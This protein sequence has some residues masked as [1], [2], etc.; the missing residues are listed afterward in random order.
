MSR[1]GFAKSLITVTVLTGFF[2]VGCVQRK[3]TINTTPSDAIVIL[4][5]EEIGRSP[6][7]VGFEW[8]GDFSVQVEKP[9]YQTLA[10]HREIKRPVR[11]RFPFDLFTDL[12]GS[13]R[14]N[15]YEWSF[16]LEPYQEPNKDELIKAAEKLRAETI[17]E[18]E[19]PVLE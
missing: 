9:G 11:D 17:T 13:N 14:I 8:Y 2:L 15:S 3:L 6:V 1:T 16:E 19:K 18:L 5:D 12:F 10:T 4:N 7:T